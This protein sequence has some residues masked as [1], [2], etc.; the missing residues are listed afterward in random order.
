MAKGSGDQ[1]RTGDQPRYEAST[2]SQS[3][4][5]ATLDYRITNVRQER[6][7]ASGA[8]RERRS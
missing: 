4:R 7:V 3:Q 1:M 8:R 6:P 2:L 5:P